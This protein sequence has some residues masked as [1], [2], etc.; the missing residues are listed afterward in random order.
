MHIN[1]DFEFQQTIIIV[2][3]F[4]H[5]QDLSTC[6]HLAFALL[7]VVTATQ[8]VISFQLNADCQKNLHILLN[9]LANTQS[10]M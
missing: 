3:A 10:I 1:R 7:M 8:R 2:I 9:S 5:Q 4:R 6:L